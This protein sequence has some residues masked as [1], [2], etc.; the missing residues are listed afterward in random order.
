VGHHIVHLIGLLGTLARAD[1]PLEPGAG[2][3]GVEHLEYDQRVAAGRPLGVR[4]QLRLLDH[5]RV[6]DL[7][8]AA[9]VDQQADGVLVLAVGERHRQGFLAPADVGV[10]P[11]LPD[12]R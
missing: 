10:V 12:L 2:V 6:P 5:P 11:A 1:G 4:A 7:A 3:G 9:V 8:A